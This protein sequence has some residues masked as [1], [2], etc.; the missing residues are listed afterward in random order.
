VVRGGELALYARDPLIPLVQHHLV[1]FLDQAAQADPVGFRP[2]AWVERSLRVYLR[3][4]ILAHGFA[5][6]GHPPKGVVWSAATS[7]SNSRQL[8]HRS[9]PWLPGRQVGWMPMR[10][11][12]TGA[13]QPGRGYLLYSAR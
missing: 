1:T 9:I 12:A 8:P 11:K 5:R 2:P 3:W 4:G 7:G 10:V 13:G 6:A